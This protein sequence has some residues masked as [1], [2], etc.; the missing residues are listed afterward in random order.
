MKQ[1][2]YFKFLKAFPEFI[3]IDD[4]V[5][6]KI[7]LLKELR[8]ITWRNKEFV[9]LLP[10]FFYNVN[11]TQEDLISKGFTGYGYNIKYKNNIILKFSVVTKENESRKNVPIG[12]TY[13]VITFGRPWT[14]YFKSEHMFMGKDE[15]KNM[16]RTLL[17]DNMLKMEK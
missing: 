3:D 15:I 13:P 5:E 14:Y 16:K 10:V 12:I 8:R 6:V 4:T 9:K 17:I 7:A 11:I 2:D 1:I